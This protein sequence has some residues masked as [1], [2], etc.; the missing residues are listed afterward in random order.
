MAHEQLVRREL[1][2]YANEDKRTCFGAAEAL[3]LWL[4]EVLI[5]LS[6]TR[7]C[8]SHALEH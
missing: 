3:T 5:D 8:L 1:N 6:S 4:R 7:K 2:H